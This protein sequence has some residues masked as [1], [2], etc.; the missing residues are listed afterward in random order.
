MQWLA[1]SDFNFGWYVEED[2]VFTGHWDE[3]F[4]L[5]NQHVN[6]GKSV[7]QDLVA[8]ITRAKRDWNKSCTM[9]NNRP[10]ARGI[11]KY[12]TKWP[13]IGISRRL[14][15]AVMRSIASPNGLNGHQ[16]PIMFPFCDQYTNHVCHYTVIP[17]KNLGVFQLGHWGRFSGP[18]NRLVYTSLGLTFG[19][20]LEP[21][22]LY[23]PIKCEA[24]GGIGKLAREMV[25]TR[26]KIEDIKLPGVRRAYF[27]PS[28]TIRRKDGVIVRI[29]RTGS[30]YGM[31]V[32][33]RLGN[34]IAV[35]SRWQ[36][37][38][39][40]D[41]AIQRT[42]NMPAAAGK[43]VRE[44]K[45]PAAARESGDAAPAPKEEDDT[46]APAPVQDEQD[47]NE[48]AA[49]VQ[50]GQVGNETPAPADSAASGGGGENDTDDSL[51]PSDKP[52]ED[53]VEV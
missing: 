22:R 53:R 43:E 3:I 51:L 17:D 34:G 5:R 52:P 37:E 39:S 8:H 35:R 32:G 12:K 20:N 45:T 23:H 4:S 7:T 27:E 38:I 16:E 18:S 33:T 30:R 31:G 9:P 14:A 11:I 28:D 29:R 19:R 25:R 36:R 13:V 50:D 6:G 15:K 46:D 47:E 10:C 24:D 2:V 44:N 49:P 48:A 41:Q 1:N 21:N 42:G 26:G 40:T